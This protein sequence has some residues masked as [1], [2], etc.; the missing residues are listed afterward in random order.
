MLVEE[1]KKIFAHVCLQRFAVGWVKPYCV[2]DFS[3]CF[4]YFQY[5]LFAVDK[6]VFCYTQS[7][8]EVAHNMVSFRKI[9]HLMMIIV[10]SAFRWT[11]EDGCL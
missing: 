4:Y 2:F 9:Y 6:L 3:Q 11:A 8:R 10:I 1:S 5:F 7:W